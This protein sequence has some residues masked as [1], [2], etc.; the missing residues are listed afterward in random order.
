MIMLLTIRKL[1]T[2][3]DKTLI[4]YLHPEI[5]AMNYEI[6]SMILYSIM[7]SLILLLPLYYDVLSTIPHF[8]LFQNLFSFNCPGCGMLRGTVALLNF[9]FFDA[10][11]YNPISLVFLIYVSLE[12]IIRIMRLNNNIDSNKRYSL[13]VLFNRTFMVLL[14]SNW[15]VSRFNA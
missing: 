9:N 5:K 4:M 14:C 3:K 15:I 10:I 6:K 1:L 7:F 11:H 8:C 2:K 13:S 12:I